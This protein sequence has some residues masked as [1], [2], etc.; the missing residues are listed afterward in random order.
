M[1][2][3]LPTIHGHFL[4][5]YNLFFDLPERLQQNRKP[6][7]EATLQA[8]DILL[9]ER[10]HVC[11]SL[12]LRNYLH[13]Y[14][15]DDLLHFWEWFEDVW[16]SAGKAINHDEN[17]VPLMSHFPND[18]P[19]NM[20]EL[21]LKR[22]LTLFESKDENCL[23]CGKENTIVELE[24][25]HH[26]VCTH[27]FDGYTGCPACGRPIDDHATFIKH[28]NILY[29]ADRSAWGNMTCLDMGSDIRVFAKNKFHSLCQI[30]QALSVSD[31]ETLS[32]IMDAF[33]H[34]IPG[35]L[36]EQFESKQMQVWGK[37]W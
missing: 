16:K 1:H 11:L 33:T 22:F 4:A 32:V 15:I 25:C 17:M 6:S 37:V 31:R 19:D 36:P 18:M 24:P 14:D 30:A 10:Y 8:L 26:N 9:A 13:N 3:F 7:S 20:D 35:W 23:I 29:K 34:D 28:Q 27:C 21:W 12:D 5:R 2:S